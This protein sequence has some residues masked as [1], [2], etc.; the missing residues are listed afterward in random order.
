VSALWLSVPWPEDPESAAGALRGKLLL[1]VVPYCD[2][3]FQ[4]LDPPAVEWQGRRVVIPR[5]R[6]HFPDREQGV[7]IL[8]VEHSDGARRT[9]YHDARHVLDPDLPTYRRS[10]RSSRYLARLTFAARQDLWIWLCYYARKAAFNP[11]NVPRLDPDEDGGSRSQAAAPVL[12]GGEVLPGVHLGWRGLQDDDVWE[13]F[14]HLLTARARCVTPH[15]F[16]AAIRV[17][18][19]F[20]L[21]A[22]VDAAAVEF[23]QGYRRYEGAFL[24][25]TDVV[26]PLRRDHELSETDLACAREELERYLAER[27]SLQARLRV[28]WQGE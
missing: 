15:D 11:R 3:V 25:C 27:A 16:R 12:R 19:L 5:D 14:R 18:D 8:H 20:G 7:R 10:G 1:N 21:N 17:F 26:V 13:A 9:V 6:R 24:P 2:R 22:H 28:R 23:R 4:R